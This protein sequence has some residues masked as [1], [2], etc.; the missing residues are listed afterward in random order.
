MLV[1]MPYNAFY[2]LFNAL[3]KSD[4]R[5]VNCPHRNYFVFLYKSF[6]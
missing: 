6:G 3:S 2:C 1:L 5:A 4:L